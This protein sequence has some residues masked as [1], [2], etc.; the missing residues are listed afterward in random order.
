VLL[1]R[2]DELRALDTV[3]DAG[4][5]LV[6]EGG[7]GIGKTSLLRLGS[8]RAAR[9]GW[10]VLRGVG[11]ELE[12]G[13]AFGVVRQLFERELAAADPPQRTQWLAGPAAAVRGLLGAPDAAPDPFAVVHG[14]YWLTVNMAAGQPVLITVDDAHWADP[15]SLRWLAYLASRVEGPGVAVVVALR[16]A[17]PASRQGPLA[18]IRTAAPAIRPALLSAAGVAAIVRAALGAGTPDA[19]CQALREASGGNPFYLGELL[20]AQPAAEPGG[21]K[22]PASEAVARHV[23]ARIRRL[24]PAALGL[25]QALAVLGDEAQLRHAMAMTGLDTDPAVR[26]AAALVRVEVLAAADPPRFLHRWCGR[27]STPRSAAT[28]GIGWTAPQL[29]SW[30]GTAPPPAGSPPT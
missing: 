16:P 12:T 13:F 29:A 22:L 3:L 21:G 15:A 14:L 4:G 9:S 17:E 5:V 8:E 2:A 19:T 28:S 6:I 10:R 23:E 25:A 18:K 24:D 7:A 26:L 1:E 30:T 20:R 27:R 11:S